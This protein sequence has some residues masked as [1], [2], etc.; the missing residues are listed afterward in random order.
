[1]STFRPEGGGAWS[2]ATA[3]TTSSVFLSLPV[4]TV[5]NG[6][7]SLRCSSGN[8]FTRVFARYRLT[9]SS[10]FPS[11]P[12]SFP[13][14]LFV[15]SYNQYIIPTLLFLCFFPFNPRYVFTMKKK[16]RENERKERERRERRKTNEFSRFFISFSR[17]DCF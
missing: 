6:C 3:T 13:P 1:M 4:N 16:K 17:L 2:V 15:F 14:S 9:K 12:S 10:C 7:F 11:I 5:R 8:L